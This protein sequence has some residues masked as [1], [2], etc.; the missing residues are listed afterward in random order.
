MEEQ[1]RQYIPGLGTLLLAILLL[2]LVGALLHDFNGVGL[3]GIGA[4][5]WG[6]AVL[7]TFVLGTAYLSRR[8][9]PIGGN[10]GWSEG[11]RLLWRNYTLGLASLLYGQPSETPVSTAS[12]RRKK[13]VQTEL[14]PSF[15]L[16]GAG[17]LPSHEAAA[18]TRGNSY[19]RADGPGLVLLRPHETISQ[20]FDLRP[21][22]GKQPVNAV[23]RDGIPVETNITARFRIRRPDPAQRRPRSVETDVIPYPYDRNA[24]FDLTYSASIRGDEQRHWMEQV[25][26]QAAALLVT[27]IHK[28][29]LNQ[30]LVSAGTEPLEQI[31]KQIEQ[32]L[33]EQTRPVTAEEQEENAVRQT[34]P[35]GIEIM[36]VAIGGLQ[37]PKEVTAKRVES[38]Q[39]VWRNKI[40]KEEIGSNLAVRQKYEEARAQAQTENIRKLLSSIEFMRQESGIDL[41]RIVTLRVIDLLESISASRTI[42]PLDSPISLARL[43]N[44][45]TRKL[46]QSLEEGGNQLS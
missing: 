8:L 18:I 28:Y 10:T 19:A 44:E 13:T 42:G 41:Y 2:G 23:T 20:V 16:L 25:A 17:F 36:G 33:K 35:K 15:K 5:L 24:L 1:K 45:A 38:W 30:L 46:R 14:P 31:K 7:V 12:R 22:S 29:T 27:E 37:L 9:L 39:V 34:L 6:G 4:L 26:P 43:A 21:Q 11:F 3:E 40:S 32:I